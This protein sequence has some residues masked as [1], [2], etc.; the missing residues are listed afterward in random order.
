MG[1]FGKKNKDAEPETPWQPAVADDAN[2]HLWAEKGF[3]SARDSDLPHAVTYWLGAIDR[4]DE[5]TTKLL[6]KLRKDIFDTVIAKMQEG[7]VQGQLIPSH[8]IAEVDAEAVVKHGD[9]WRPLLSTEVFYHVK[10]N[11]DSQ[12]GP[13]TVTYTFIAGAYSILGYLRFVSDIKEAAEKCGEVERLGKQASQLC[14]GFK[15]NR[16]EGTVKPKMG[17]TFCYIINTLFTN[18]AI[19]LERKVAT[20][21]HEQIE[22]IKER[23]TND[24]VDL[25]EHLSNALQLT[26]SAGTSGRLKQKKRVRE[27]LNEL[28][29]YID[30]LVGDAAPVET[31]EEA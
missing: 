5:D 8:M 4:Y 2:W 28:N 3:E 22:A 26:M 1:L 20:L 6:D 29:A 19:L 16:Y 21:S 30:L 27:V 15:G 18:L 11:L 12:P 9:K 10:E 13:E 14:Y 7:A 25:L 31:K 24:R 23:R 17:G